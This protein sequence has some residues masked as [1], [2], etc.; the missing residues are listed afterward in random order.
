MFVNRTGLYMFD[1]LP[2]DR[3]MG[4]EYFA[5][6]ITPSLASICYSNGRDFRKKKP[7]S[8]DSAS[9]HNSKAVT[10]KLVK[11]E[12]QRMRLPAYRPDLSLCA[13]FLFGYLKNK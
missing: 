13:F 7:C 5:E 9:I 1:I 12:L 3:K 11:G 10:K 6:Q 8:F 4:A 2:Q